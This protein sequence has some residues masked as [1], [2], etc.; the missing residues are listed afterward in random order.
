MFD[1]EVRRAIIAAACTVLVSPLARAQGIT[2]PKQ[3][4]GGSVAR[5]GLWPAAQQLRERCRCGHM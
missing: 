4:Q 5:A 3:G 2:Q 1:L